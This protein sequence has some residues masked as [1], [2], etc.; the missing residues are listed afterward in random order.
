MNSEK[1]VTIKDVARESGYS[2]A[3]IHCALNGKTA[4]QVRLWIRGGENGRSKV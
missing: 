4:G 3:T 1:R 2:I